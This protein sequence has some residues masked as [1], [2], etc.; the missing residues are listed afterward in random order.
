MRF[1]A[2][3]ELSELPRKSVRDCNICISRGKDS[4]RPT[5]LVLQTFDPMSETSNPRY[6]DSDSRQTRRPTR[7]L[8]V[9]GSC[10][11]R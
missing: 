6:A 7:P 9:R 2:K 8:P 4:R 3:S 10:E 11:P 5:P 1:R